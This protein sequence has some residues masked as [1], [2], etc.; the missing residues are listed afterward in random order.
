MLSKNQLKRFAKLKQ[1]K[2]RDAEGLFVAEGE[3]LVQD[4]IARGV[5]AEALVCVENADLPEAYWGVSAEE[6]KRLSSLDNPNGVLG[7]FHKPEI[8][9]RRQSWTLVLDGVRDPGNLGTILR[10]AD[11]FGLNKVVC[12]MDTVDCYN[13]KTV[14]A[15]M[16]SVASIRVEYC[17]LSPYLD[18]ERRPV[19]GTF[20]NGIS[21]GSVELPAE[22]VLVM[23]NE[24]QGIRPEISTV[25]THPLKIDKHPSAQAESLNVATAAAIFMAVLPIRK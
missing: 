16:G 24:G 6:F 9:A 20:M 7:V 22:G 21:L 8:E 10:C 1:K 18:K 12:S 5:Q 4:L 2:H 14:Q 11:W 3:K 15:S 19:Y 23:G 25:I 13:P 17:A